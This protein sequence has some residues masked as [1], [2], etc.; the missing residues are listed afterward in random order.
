MLKKIIFAVTISLAALACNEST[1]TTPDDDS[2]VAVPDKVPMDTS[3]MNTPDVK[4]A[5]DDQLTS[6]DTLFEDG[7]I[8]TSWANA[9][10]D[11][12]VGFKRFIIVFKD[13][14]KAD[15][16]DSIAAHI[17][18]PVAPAK[19]ADIFKEKYADIFDK[20]L[21]AVVGKQ[22]L[23]RIFRNAD[24]AMIG[25]GQLWFTVNQGSYMITAIN[26]TN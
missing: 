10:F 2:I 16:K 8:P 23:D 1:E 15:N 17:N 4:N 19:T 22:R 25:S 11:D 21:K 5:D 7:S 20:K 14:V 18:F 24:G 12:P 9:G 6:V 3:F 26:K 13:W